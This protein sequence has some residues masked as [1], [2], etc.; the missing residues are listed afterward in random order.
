MKTPG[1]V[2]ADLSAL[3]KEAAAIAINRIFSDLA[4]ITDG[5]LNLD[6]AVNA[7]ALDSA[8]TPEAADS[9][10]DMVTDMVIADATT[11]ATP[12]TLGD[13]VEKPATPVA[14]QHAPPAYA[15]FLNFFFELVVLIAG[16]VS[17]MR[18]EGDAE[19]GAAYI[20]LLPFS[21]YV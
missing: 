13:E 11:A 18:S 10:T 17:R 1:Y 5:S 7:A 12:P 6:G 15:D 4:A 2:G 19:Y 14:D 16:S 9:T 3:T 21:T 20:W 8:V